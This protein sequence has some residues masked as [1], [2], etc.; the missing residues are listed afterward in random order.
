MWTGDN[1]CSW[2]HMAVGIKMV[3][4]NGLAGMTFGGGGLFFSLF[5]SIVLDL[6]LRFTQ[7]TLV[8]SSATP[9]QTF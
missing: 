9:N 7:R 1:L 8:V 5:I 2:E 3:L 6:T 4:A